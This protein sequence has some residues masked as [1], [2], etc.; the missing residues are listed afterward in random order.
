V[1]GPHP[2][3]RSPLYEDTVTCSPDGPCRDA[4][5]QAAHVRQMRRATCRHAETERRT[6][7]LS[8]GTLALSV[9]PGC[10]H[11]RDSAVDVASAPAAAVTM[12]LRASA[13]MVASVA[14]MMCPT[15]GRTTRQ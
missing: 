11:G 1:S 10:R 9:A 2:G 8:D 4:G 12:R 15:N 14:R 3:R 5:A 7:M 13:P 6:I